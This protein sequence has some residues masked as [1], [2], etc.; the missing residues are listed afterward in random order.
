MF[1]KVELRHAAYL[2]TDELFEACRDSNYRQNADM[3]KLVRILE[4]DE[5]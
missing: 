4:A 1:A 5:A 3:G 2:G